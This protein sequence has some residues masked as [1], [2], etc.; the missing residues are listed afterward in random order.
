MNFDYSEEQQL[1]AA[2]IRRLVEKQYDFETRKAIV[3]SDSCV[4]DAVWRSLADLGLLALPLPADAGGFDGGAVDLM[5]AMEAFGEAL[6]VE[7]YLA[8]VAL[9]AQMIRR[10]GRLSSIR[11]G[12]RASPPARR[13]SPSRTVSAR[14][15][16][17]PASRRARS[18]GGAIRHRRR[19]SVVLQAQ[20]PTRC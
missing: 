1:L 4:S 19:K 3:A 17:S 13:S 9:G 20:A 11:R 12:C 2:S 14:A 16:T 5:S 15:L 18:D 8:T 10:G 6:L 7:P